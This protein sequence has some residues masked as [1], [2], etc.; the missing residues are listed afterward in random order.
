MPSGRG[1][2]RPTEQWRESWGELRRSYTSSQVR[3]QACCGMMAARVRARSMKMEWRVLVLAAA[4]AA[5]LGGRG[6]PAQLPRV[7]FL[8]T[9]G[10]ISGGTQPLNAAGPRALAPRLSD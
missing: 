4:V 2:E 10:T 6:S 5:G 3:P 7:H 8:A 9:G 1:E